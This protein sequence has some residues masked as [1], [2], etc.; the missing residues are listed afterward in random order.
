MGTIG[1]SEGRPGRAER[2]GEL[3]PLGMMNG[4]SGTGKTRVR[5]LVRYPDVRERSLGRLERRVFSS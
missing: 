5:G 3:R 1:E 4:K 2:V